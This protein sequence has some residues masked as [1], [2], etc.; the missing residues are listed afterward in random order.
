MFSYNEPLGLPRGSIRGILTLVL[1]LPVPVVL[2]LSAVG[3]GLPGET[4]AW[5]GA[6]VILV[7]K[8]YFGARQVEAARREYDSGADAVVGDGSPSSYAI[9]E[10]DA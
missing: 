10:G 8:D 5:Y 6:M 2:V 7:L 9:G 3:R 1:V 4:L